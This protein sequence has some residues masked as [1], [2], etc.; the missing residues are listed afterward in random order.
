MPENETEKYKRLIND[1]ITDKTFDKSA[2]YLKSVRKGI[3]KYGVITKKQMQAVN[4]I[5]MG[6]TK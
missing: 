4:N 5:Y 2:N 1:M 6:F 3:E